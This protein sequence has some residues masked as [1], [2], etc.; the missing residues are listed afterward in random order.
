MI[1]TLILV[2]GIAFTTITAQAAPQLI[3]GGDEARVEY[4]GAPVGSIVGGGTVSLTGGGMDRSA[5][6][7]NVTAVAGR[8]A[9]IIG[10]GESQRVLRPTRG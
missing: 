3:G 2:T 10:G 6:H 7:G 1:R 5:S 4:G 8:P 9:Q